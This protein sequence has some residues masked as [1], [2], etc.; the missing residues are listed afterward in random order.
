MVDVTGVLDWDNAAVDN[1]PSQR[2]TKRMSRPAEPVDIDDRITSYN[3]C[4]TK[5]LRR[6]LDSVDPGGRIWQA[7]GPERAVGCVSYNFV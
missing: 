3:V 1:T 5:L 4:Y 7:L 6:H 2:K